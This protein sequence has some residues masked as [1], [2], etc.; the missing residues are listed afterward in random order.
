MNL[1]AVDKIIQM[2]IHQKTQHESI[3]GQNTWPAHLRQQL[4]RLI[5]ERYNEQYKIASLNH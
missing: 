5:S 1:K 2:M 4:R 3:W